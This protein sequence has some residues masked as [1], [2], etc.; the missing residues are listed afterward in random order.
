M[1]FR[2][3]T[4]LILLGVIVL[5]VFLLSMTVQQANLLT[6]FIGAGLSASGLILRRRYAY[7][8]PKTNRFATFRSIFSKNKED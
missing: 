4:A 1:L 5:V 8:I 6:L 7:E 3:G 2:M